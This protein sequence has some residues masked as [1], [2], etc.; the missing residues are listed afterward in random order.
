MKTIDFENNLNVFFM[1]I[2]GWALKTDTN[3]YLSFKS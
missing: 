3:I 1:E 2:K